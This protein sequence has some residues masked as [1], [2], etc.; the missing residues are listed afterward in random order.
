M[1][2]RRRISRFD[3]HRLIAKAAARKKGGYHDE[4]DYHEHHHAAAIEAAAGR[5]WRILHVVHFYQLSNGRTR[6]RYPSKIK[7]YSL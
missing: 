5:S 2:G 4:D 6:G 7:I 1:L 3:I